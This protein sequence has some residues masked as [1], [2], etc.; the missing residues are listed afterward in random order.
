MEKQMA[1]EM[2][3]KNEEKEKE[4]KE[5]ERK[6]TI[7]K[8]MHSEAVYAGRNKALRKTTP[9]VSRRFDD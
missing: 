5:Q 9:R 2:R 1:E 3:R 6:T 4:R 8:R 7:T